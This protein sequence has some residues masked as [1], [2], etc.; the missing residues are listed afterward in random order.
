MQ[1]IG[2]ATMDLLIDTNVFVEVGLSQAKAEE[3]SEF[4]GRV[5]QFNLFISDFSLHSISVILI[6]QRRTEPLLKFYGD[7]IRTGFV[8]VLSIPE[9]EL[10]EVVVRAEKFGLDFDDAYQY[11]LAEQHSLEI[12]SYDSDFD[13]TPRG[14]KTPAD[15]P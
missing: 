10:A 7:I 5:S 11:T 12:V 15:F 6:R 2:A 4:F 8:R 9:D 3:A 13:R 14:R 1:T